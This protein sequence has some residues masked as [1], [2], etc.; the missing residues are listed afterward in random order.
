MDK[1]KIKQWIQDKWKKDINSSEDTN[2]EA[3]N[4]FV[5]SVLSDEVASQ[6]VEKAIEDEVDISLND[7]YLAIIMK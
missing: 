3:M 7:V 1:E 2:N 6:M 4:D 5:K